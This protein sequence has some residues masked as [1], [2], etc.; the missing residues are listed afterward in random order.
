ME[1]ATSPCH[2]EDNQTDAQVDNEDDNGEN[3]VEMEE[4]VHYHVSLGFIDRWWWAGLL[5]GLTAPACQV[6]K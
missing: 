3:A 1:T 2:S 5:A 4:G 6:E